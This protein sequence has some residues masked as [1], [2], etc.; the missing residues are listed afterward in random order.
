MTKKD[1]YEFIRKR[2]IKVKV[3]LR[4]FNKLKEKGWQNATDAELDTIML[5]IGRLND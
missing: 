5:L 3:I 1:K 4:R 2:A